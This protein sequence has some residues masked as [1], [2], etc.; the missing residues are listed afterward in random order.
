MTTCWPVLNHAGSA[1][2]PAKKVRAATAHPHQKASCRSNSVPAQQHFLPASSSIS[3]VAN[4]G[5]GH[6]MQKLDRITM[7][8]ELRAVRMLC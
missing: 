5:P 6:A 2:Q 3:S 7:R 1:T 8:D 4:A